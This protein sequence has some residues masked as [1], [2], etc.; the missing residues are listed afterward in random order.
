MGKE[1]GIA[2]TDHT[3]NPW[4]GCEKVSEGCKHCYAETF[5]VKRQGLPVWGAQA[6]RKVAAESTWKNLLKW[7]REA[8]RDGVKRRVFVASLADIFEDYQGPTA[9]AVRAA[10]FRLITTIGQTPNLIYL[11]LTK[12]PEN[13]ARLWPVHL[14]GVQHYGNIWIGC[15][16]ENQ[17]RAEERIPWLLEIPSVVRFVSYEPALE[18]VDFTRIQVVKPA[19]PHGP[20]A[21]L[22]GLTCYV[23][24]PD[25]VRP[26]RVDWLIVGGESGLGAR[27]F[28]LTWARSSVAQCKAAGVSVFVKQMGSKPWSSDKA[29]DY[30]GRRVWMWA[31]GDS[32][33]QKLL[34][35]FDDTKGGDMA[36]WPE[37]LRVRE[38]P[39]A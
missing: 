34:L 25:D 3:F 21:W 17:K 16:V 38:F 35:K 1:T 8:E 14:P 33:E 31:S 19:P 37:D 9:E 36:E 18:A 27:P 5:V 15:T 13:V 26:R 20:G 10:R 32:L 39:N 11:L 29:K 4:R 22:N 7:N 28:D 30:P 6:E 12:R 23:A 2:W 24:G